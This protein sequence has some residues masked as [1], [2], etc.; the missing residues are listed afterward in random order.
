MPVDCLR[1][2]RSFRPLRLP[3]ILV[4]LLLIV[5][6]VARAADLSGDYSWSPMKIG[7]GGWVVGLSIN[8]AAKDILYARTDVSGAYRWNPAT[9]SWKQVVTAAS[10]PPEYVSYAKYCGVDSIVGA[11][12]DANIAYMMLPGQPYMASP[13][14]VF[15]STNRGETWTATGFKSTGIKADANGAGRQEGERLAVDPVNSDVVYYG[16]STDG[17][18]LTENAGATWTKVATIPAGKP[19]HGANTIVFDRT[20]GTLKTA[21]GTKRTRVAYVSV[22]EGGIFRTGDAGAT[23]RKISDP[24]AGDKGKPRDAIMGPDG[25]YY[26]VYDN[27]KGATGAVWKYTAANGWIDIT[28]PGPEGGS[29]SYWAIT[30]DPFD[31]LHVV[32][33]ING[34]KTFVSTD[35]GAH[36]SYHLFTLKSPE[37]GWLGTQANYFLSTGQIAFDP[38]EK[39]K[40]WYAEGFGVWWTR[41]LNS[42][43]I[44]W[45]AASKGIEEVCGNDVIAPPGG[46]PVGAMWDV[47]VFRFNNVDTYTAVRSQPGFMSA[48]SLDYCPSD[49]RFLVAVFRSHLDFVPHAK[50]SGFS[51]DGGLTWTRF[52]AVEKGTQPP[53]LDYGVIAVSANNPD[54]IVWC[55]SAGKLPY[56]TADRGES[57]KQSD[58]GGPQQT[59]HK[60][61]S[62]SHKPL[63]ADRVESDTFYLYTPQAGLF[64]STDGGVTF[65]RLGDP[66]PNCWNAILKSTPGQARDLWFAAGPAAGLYHSTD[67]GATWTQ[68]KGIEGAANIGFGKAKTGNSPT[69]YVAGKVAGTSGIFR[70]TDQGATWDK[71]VDYPLGIFDSIDALDGDKDIFGQVYVCFASA[72]FAY[73]K[74]K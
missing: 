40:L 24:G 70:S 7:G 8:P 38:Y 12:S 53:D 28:P 39:G 5:Q 33:M 67:G 55:P 43:Q 4:S 18:W 42:I 25:T 69:L 26:V 13:G 60:S 46:K 41:D 57:W 31:P 17:L 63:C 36:W 56:Y 45:Q 51:T 74:P 52:P 29:K 32:A 21:S 65:A 71:I 73:G 9:G 2:L 72:G 50:S 22:E 19:P 37:I 23:W 10:L 35:Q 48:W 3:T 49:P 59:G 54:H 20:G 44:P 27:E 6:P 16:S 11:P 58:F 68:T 14:Q 34:G 30:V 66:A 1:G 61:F 47:G 64:R 15:R 62:T